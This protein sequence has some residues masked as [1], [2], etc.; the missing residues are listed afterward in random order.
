MQLVL[1]VGDKPSKLNTHPDIAFVGAACYPRLMAWC[2]ELQVKPIFIN[3]TSD[4]F[5]TYILCA[6]GNKTPVVALGNNASKAL[7]KYDKLY[8]KLPHPSGLNRQINDEIFVKNQLKAC[9]KW[10]KARKN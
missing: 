5:E 3:R 9:K 2:A 4:H 6:I 8:F 10:L 1:F 7:Q